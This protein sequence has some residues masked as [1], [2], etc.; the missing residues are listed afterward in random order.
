MTEEERLTIAKERIEFILK[1]YNVKIRCED[2]YYDEFYLCVE[3]DEY[4]QEKWVEIA[5][6]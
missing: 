6:V 4:T 1:T 3:N 5:N 2:T